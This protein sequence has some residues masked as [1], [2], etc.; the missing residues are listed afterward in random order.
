MDVL[1]LRFDDRDAVTLVL[2]TNNAFA[3]CHICT[4]P[5]RTSNSVPVRLLPFEPRLKAFTL[6]V[7]FETGWPLS[8]QLC[9]F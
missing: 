6:N 9:L 4:K 2:P 7:F 3:E 1:L 5:C 8:C